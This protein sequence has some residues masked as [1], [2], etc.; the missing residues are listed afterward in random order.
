MN[1]SDRRAW[2]LLALAGAVSAALLLWLNRGGTFFNDELVWF[3]NL[4]GDN[5]LRS[6]LIPHNSHL[7]GTTRALYLLTME[8]IGT[9]YVVFRILDAI[10]VLLCAGLFFALAKRRV[11]NVIAI[12]PA[13]LLLF[14]GSAWAHVV[15][16]IGFTVL[17]SIAAGLVALIA[18]ERDDR[19]GDVI[20]CGALCLSVFTFTVGLGYLVGA[21]I[22]VLLR[23]DR[24]R[25]LWIFAIP[26]VLYSAWWL[27]AQQFDQGRTSSG[28]IAEIVPFIGKSLALS[29]GS[30]T[31][32]NLSIDAAVH[33]DLVQAPPS[34]GWIPAALVA[35]ALVWR[36]ARG[37]VPKSLWASLG[38]VLTYWVAAALASSPLL[39]QEYAV[40]YVFPGSVGVL[41][42]LTDLGRGL[43]FNRAAVAAVIALGAVSLA[44]NLDFLRDGGRAYREEYTPSARSTLAAFELAS[45]RD[46]GAGAGPAATRVVNP[47]VVTDLIPIIGDQYLTAVERFG[48]PAFTLD[49]V[50]AEPDRFRSLFD[51]ELLLAYGTAL[52]PAPAP[53]DR[54]ACESSAG[55]I[56]LP[57]GG[58]LIRAADEGAHLS[59][60][61]F[62]PAPGY[63]LGAMP[64]GWVELD[65]P[66]DGAPEPWRTAPGVEL[67][68]C[69]P[70]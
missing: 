5:D 40:R 7:H 6:I 60:S 68:V 1:S 4:G 61:R 33:G 64:G 54:A 51:E 50:R 26:L 69:P 62:G 27:W 15:A 46:P 31:G 2:A 34:L 63:D 3:E 13:I 67:E 32:L 55:Q 53:A 41:L 14:F 25:R 58:A 52:T 28:Q 22:S 44:I 29:A 66:S 36:I 59:L 37:N 49:D 17:F 57:P 24:L 56:E 21:A 30:L 20:A 10:A 48:S 23:R 43:R 9:K 8:T 11:G 65:L 35:G 42:V 18:L 38:V 19:R 12:V 39:P 70:G 16:P 47:P 45:G